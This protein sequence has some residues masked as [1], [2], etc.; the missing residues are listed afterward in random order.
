MSGMSRGY[1]KEP[2]KFSRH[3]RTTTSD[4]SA[5][6]H[7][8][9]GDGLARKIFA[10][11]GHTQVCRTPWSYIGKR[12]TLQTN[13]MT[14][15]AQRFRRRTAGAPCPQIPVV[16]NREPKPRKEATMRHPKKISFAAVICAL[17]VSPPCRRAAGLQRQQH[18][19]E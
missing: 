3:V 19:A 12:D 14:A 16:S 2:H 13:P 8:Y 17:T 11:D 18:R 15:G 10:N 4:P 9:R 6:G 5:R 1:F 7:N